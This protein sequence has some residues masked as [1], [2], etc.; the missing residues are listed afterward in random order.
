MASVMK[1]LLVAIAQGQLL[2]SQFKFGPA[3]QLTRRL[4]PELADRGW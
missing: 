3:D 4:E 2:E 1:S